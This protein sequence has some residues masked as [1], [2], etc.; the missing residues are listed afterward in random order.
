[1]KELH[2]MGEEELSNLK[3]FQAGHRD[4]GEVGSLHEVDIYKLKI[5]NKLKITL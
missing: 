3:I 5:T 4:F 2:K 1:M